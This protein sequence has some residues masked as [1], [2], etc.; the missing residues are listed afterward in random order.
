MNKP[1]DELLGLLDL[2]RIEVN[3][4]RG[5]SPTDRWQRV[6]GGQVI[7]QALV[8][9]NRTVK[10]RICHS[11]HGYFLRPG[12]PK[13]PILYE[14]DRSRD[15]KSFTSRRVVAIQHGKQIFHLAASFQIEEEGLNHQEDF[16]NVLGPDEL[17]TEDELR[18]KIAEK[19]P[20]EFKE[21][22]LVK[23]WPVEVRPIDPVDLLNPEPKEPKQFNWFRARSEI[24]NDVALHQCVLAYMSDM[25]LLDTCTNP[26]GINF[27][28]PKLRS[29]S[30][31]HA[32]WFH[33]PFKANEWLL[34]QQDSPSASG[35][36]GFNRGNIFNTDGKLIASVAQEG[37]I[38]VTGE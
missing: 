23:N 8:A 35:A 34:Y 22:F 24:P 3:L 4:F 32:M 17:L 9:A 29:A 18:K 36:R 16:P 1:L 5:H 25:T 19:L 26:H 27:M 15:G 12:D 2:E 7:G 14:V 31:D 11:L 13:V 38:R 21:S 37:L 30:L 28:N 20:D 6:Y 10:N 33:R